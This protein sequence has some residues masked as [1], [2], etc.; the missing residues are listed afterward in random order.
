M[1]ADR[2]EGNMLAA[3]QE[4]EKL[5]LLVSGEGIDEDDVIDAV[6]DSARFDVFQLADAVVAGDLPRALRIV[7]GLRE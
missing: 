4:V 6:R 1:I 3:A 2:V 7:R 5:A